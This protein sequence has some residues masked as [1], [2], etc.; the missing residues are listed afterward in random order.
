M[1]DNFE[2]SVCGVKIEPEPKVISFF[3]EDD[4]INLMDTDVCRPCLTGAVK[5]WLGKYKNETSEIYRRYR[6]ELD[7][8]A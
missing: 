2:C 8:S 7:R 3:G 1:I 4:R 5:W 6:D